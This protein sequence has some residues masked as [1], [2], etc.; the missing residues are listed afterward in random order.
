MQSPA[1]PACD[2]LH[3]DTI[4][5]HRLYAFFLIEHATRR[6]RILGVT[7]H[8]TGAR[9]TQLA[10]NLTMDLEDAGHRFHFLIRDRDAKFDAV[11][12]AIDIR[13]IKTPVQAPQANAIAECFVGVIRRELVDRIMIINQRHAAAVLREFEHHYNTHRPHRALGQLA[14]LRSLP[15]CRTNATDTARR[16]DDSVGCCTSIS[17]S[18]EV[19]TV[20]GTHRL[21]GRGVFGSAAGPGRYSSTAPRPSRLRAAEAVS[22]RPRAR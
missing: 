4:T 3:L 10:R 22:P 7:A 14:L 1:I 9:L 11:F 6:V 15:Q 18:R 2:L 8:P 21:D 19:C 13:I 16:Q 20:S 12:S 5:L 17:R